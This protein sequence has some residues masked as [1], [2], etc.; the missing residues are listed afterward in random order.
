MSSKEKVSKDRLL[1]LKR[2]LDG[3]LQGNFSKGQIGKMKSGINQIDRLIGNARSDYIELTPG[4]LSSL[5]NLSELQAN[6]RSVAH[7]NHYW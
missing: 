5:E 7:S 2:K 1:G 4:Q 3:K 6:S